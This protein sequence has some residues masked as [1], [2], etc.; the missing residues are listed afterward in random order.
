VLIE[1]LKIASP[2]IFNADQG[3]PYTSLKFIQI[4]LDHGIQMS[5]DGKGRA[6]DNVF[7]ERLWKSLKYE[8]TDLRDYLGAVE[9]HTGVS[10]YF[11]FYNTQR[12]H[13]SLD[14]RTPS[15]VYHGENI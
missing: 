15:A 1:A 6:I 2:E 8:D 11:T 4:L 10:L 7:I 12:Y 9:L 3:S 5:M 13:S 14:Y